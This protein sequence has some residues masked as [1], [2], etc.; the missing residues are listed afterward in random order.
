MSKQSS[1]S[2]GTLVMGLALA[3]LLA[4]AVPLR[5]QS[6]QPLAFRNSSQTVGDFSLS[7]EQLDFVRDHDPH[8]I[9]Y[10]FENK[11]DSAVEITAVFSSTD[12][13]RPLDDSGQQVESVSCERSVAAGESV[14]LP[15]QFA[16]LPGSFNAHYPLRLVVTTQQGEKSTRLEAIRVIEVRFEKKQSFEGDPDR[17]VFQKGLSLLERPRRVWVNLPEEELRCLGVDFSGADEATRAVCQWEGDH[18]SLHPPFV[19][20]GGSLWL[21]YPLQ[22]PDSDSITFR[23]GCKIRQ[24]SPDEPV[25]DGVTFRVWGTEGDFESKKLLD[26]IHTDAKTWQNRAAD[27]S[28]FASKAMT[29]WIEISP[30]PKNDT[31]CDGCGLRGLT[32][33]ALAPP[34]KEPEADPVE[35]TLADGFTARVA[36]GE[37]GLFD[38]TVTL[39]APDGRRVAYQGVSI[40]LEGVCPSAEDALIEAGPQCRYDADAKRLNCRAT[41]VINDRPETITLSVYEL[42]GLLIVEVPEGNPAKI[43]PLSLGP[44]SESIERFYYGHGMVCQHPTASLR[45]DGEGHRLSTSHVG[46]DYA[47]GLSILMASETP[48]DF[49]AVDPEKQLFTLEVSGVTRVALRP[50][51]HGAFDAAIRFR[52]QSPWYAVPGKGVV[53]KAG[54]LVFDNW[55]SDTATA[56]SLVG[57][58]FDYGVTDSLYIHHNWQKWGYDVR[59]PDIWGDSEENAARGSLEELRALADLCRSRDVPF[60]LHDNYIDFYP[61]AEGFTYDDIVFH[62][63]GTPYKA[64]IN[65]GAEAQSYRFRPDKIFPFVERN[66]ALGKKYLPQADASFVDVFSSIHMFPFYDREGNFHPLAETRDGWKKAFDMIDRTLTQVVD[67][68]ERSGISISEAGN[69][70]LIGSLDG[71]DAEWIP[72]SSVPAAG[73]YLVP[74]EKWERTPWF[75]A[76]NH[77]N[78]SRH[79]VGYED[80]YIAKKNVLL[81]GTESDDYISMEILGGVDLMVEWNCLFS[82]SVRKH[83]LAQHIVRSRA[84]AEIRSVE[85]AE[86]DRTGGRDIARQIVRWSDGTTVFGNRGADDWTLPDGSILPRYGVKCVNPNGM[87]LFIGRNPAAPD[88]VIEYSRRIDGSFYLNGRGYPSRRIYAVA[89]R[90]ASGEILPDGKFKIALDWDA[91]EPLPKDLQI[92]VYAFEP[93]LGY[94]HNPKGWFCAEFVPSVPTTR[95]GSEGNK[96]IRTDEITVAVPDDIPSG[97]YEILTGLCEGQSRYP[98]IGNNDNQGR[99]AVASLDIV[100]KQD[101]SCDLTI[102]PLALREDRDLFLRNIGNKTPASDGRIS[103]L[104]ALYV[105]PGRDIWRL[106]PIPVAESFEVTLDEQKLGRQID[107]ISVENNPVPFRRDGE[108]VTFTVEAKDAL[109]YTLTLK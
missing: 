42:N 74:C 90:L 73:C 97:H 72:I 39:T 57:K 16:A 60:A 99:Y 18:F 40:N 12:T 78:Y 47:N 6:D 28:A 41:L 64:W 32:V 54:R 2:F 51:E 36:P 13:V 15:F 44:G 19:P 69:D 58:A 4:W 43:G 79:G 22:M 9:T 66:F 107:G 105:I 102:K 106:L 103:T 96:T 49:L 100:R 108:C 26:E 93:H 53:R 63:N 95:W 61:D 87:E 83:Y 25:S 59:L 20:Q 75:A 67:G 14:A 81:H 46:A 88:E 50:S 84:A 38:G 68:Q 48:P 71:A 85:F 45:I 91:E 92:F 27:L 23:Y 35:F 101:N 82:A 77:T 31:T 11:S 1:L 56:I 24:N 37:Y 8:R 17:T 34:A 104:G 21:E 65:Y 80:R 98:L 5:G 94:G 109:W 33:S 89:P 7:A 10:T 52:E 29:L 30:G 62:P 70:F 76:V 55:S 86:G 3:L